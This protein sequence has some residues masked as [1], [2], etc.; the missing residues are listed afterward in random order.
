V[1]QGEGFDA[2][3]TPGGRGQFDVLDDGTIVFSKA[4]EHRFPETDE[5]LAA[6]R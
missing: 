1:L 6:L 2:S 4:T 3:A 5:I